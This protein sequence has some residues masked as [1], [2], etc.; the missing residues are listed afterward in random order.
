[1][2]SPRTGVSV[3]CDGKSLTDMTVTGDSFTC[4]D[5]IQFH[6]ACG[7]NYGRQIDM[8]APVQFIGNIHKGSSLSS[9]YTTAKMVYFMNVASSKIGNVYNNNASFWC[10]MI[11]LYGNKRM[12]S[13]NVSFEYKVK[14]LKNVCD[15]VSFASYDDRSNGNIPFLSFIDIDVA[16]ITDGTKNKNKHSFCSDIIG[17]D[18]R[19]SGVEQLSVLLQN[20]LKQTNGPILKGQTVTTQHCCSATSFGFRMC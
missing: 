4:D 6:S 17:S 2:R 8:W 5:N 20:A 18:W 13:N 14:A 19:T 16:A 11:K 1:M 12:R 15:A 7:V 10:S 3:T 9:I